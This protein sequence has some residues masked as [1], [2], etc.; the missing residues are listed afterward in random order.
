M[1][2]TILK[3]IQ[4]CSTCSMQNR[5]KVGRRNH[6]RDYCQSGLDCGHSSRDRN[7]WEDSRYFR[8]VLKAGLLSITDETGVENEGK[9]L[10]RRVLR[11]VCVLVAYLSHLSDTSTMYL[12]R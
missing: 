12:I 5:L 9:K 4:N 2:L 8:N 7:K 3:K 10:I 6:F 1:I 11:F